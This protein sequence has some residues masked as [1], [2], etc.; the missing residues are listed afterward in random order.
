MKLGL[1]DAWICHFDSAKGRSGLNLRFICFASKGIRA[2]LESVHLPPLPAFLEYLK[3][4]SKQ[5]HKT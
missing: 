2:G 4:P 5:V 1:R 3:D